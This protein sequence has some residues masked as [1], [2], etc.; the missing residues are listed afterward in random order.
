MNT[1][2][3]LI[4]A[5]HIGDYNVAVKFSDN[6]EGIVSFA[7]DIQHGVFRRIGDVREFEKLKIDMFGT[8]LTWDIDAPALE[9]PDA[10]VDWLYSVC[11]S[12]ETAG[13]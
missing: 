10:C 11:H 13:M 12:H 6:T 1:T 8:V 3:T 7:E 2:P 4:S 5:T 9:I